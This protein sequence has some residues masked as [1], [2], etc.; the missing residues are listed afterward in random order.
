MSGRFR[1]EQIMGVA[2]ELIRDRERGDVVVAAGG[3]LGTANATVEPADWSDCEE[4]AAFPS[5]A[6]LDVES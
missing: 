5:L 3:A 6:V 2:D 1:S 4:D